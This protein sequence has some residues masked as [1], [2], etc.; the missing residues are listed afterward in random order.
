MFQS[1]QESKKN[2]ELFSLPSLLSSSNLPRLFESNVSQNT[3]GSKASGSTHFEGIA[4]NSVLKGSLS[5]RRRLETARVLF[6]RRL[7]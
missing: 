2:W 6:S 1:V 4:M 7:P 5:K 3:I